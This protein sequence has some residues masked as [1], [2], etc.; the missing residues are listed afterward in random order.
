[1]WLTS[2]SGCCEAPSAADA[3][4][5]P[6]MRAA[7]SLLRANASAKSA[8]DDPT[9]TCTPPLVLWRYLVSWLALLA[10]FYPHKQAAAS[11]SAA[12]RLG[13][14]A[15]GSQLVSHCMCML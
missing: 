2:A 3:S 14:L 11:H 4:W 12:C 8:Q 9:D 13:H 5:Q 15:A 7:P 1:M 10:P 6:S